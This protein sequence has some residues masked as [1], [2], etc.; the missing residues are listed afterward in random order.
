MPLPAQPSCAA[1]SKGSR[2]ALLGGFAL[3]VGGVGV[4][5]PLPAQRVLAY[6]CLTTPRGATCPRPTLAE[7]LWDSS[8]MQR[9]HANLRTALWRVRRADPGLVISAGGT[10]RL[11]DTVSVD[12]HEALAWADSM[13]EAGNDAPGDAR[14]AGL[15]GELLPAWEDEWLLIERERVRQLQVHAFDALAHRLLVRGCYPQA[16]SAA[17]TALAAEPLRESAYATLIDIYLDEGN[18]AEAIHQ[19]DRYAA[20]LWNELGLAPSPSLAARL[21]PRRWPPAA[22][23]EGNPR[24]RPRPVG[25]T[26]T[27]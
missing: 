25:Q 1:R 14:E 21:P 24:G 10:V 7:R 2:V 3:R 6:L 18:V 23:A 22:A 17:L 16:I 26:P 13:L 11:G 5:L 9:A 27:R 8:S 4:S 12:L 19:Y 20:L 15:A